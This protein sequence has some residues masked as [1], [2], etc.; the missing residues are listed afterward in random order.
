MSILLDTKTNRRFY[1]FD[2]SHDDRAVLY[3]QDPKRIYRCCCREHNQVELKLT[4]ALKFF[5]IDKTQIHEPDCER[6]SEFQESKLLNKAFLRQESSTF[7]TQLSDKYSDD[8]KHDNI[9]RKFPERS[10]VNKELSFVSF[11]KKVNMAAYERMMKTNKK[12][13]NGNHPTIDRKYIERYIWSVLKSVYVK[14]EDGEMSIYEMDNDNSFKFRHNYHLLDQTREFECKKSKIGMNY[15]VLP[16]VNLKGFGSSSIIMNEDD[17]QEAKKQFEKEY[18]IRFDHRNNKVM[19]FVK[20]EKKLD[21]IHDINPWKRG[22]VCFFIISNR[23]LYAK[24]ILESKIYNEIENCLMEEEAKG[25]HIQFFKPYEYT[26]GAYGG[27]FLEDGII[28]NSYKND[29]SIVIEIFEDNSKNIQAERIG[30]KKSFIKK[31]KY[32]PWFYDIQEQEK[33]KMTDDEYLAHKIQQLKS[34][35]E[36]I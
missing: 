29:K 19:A 31:S 33:L 25:K 26:P 24:S 6:S 36:K 10:K 17:F 15:Y 35:L 14:T 18:G 5:P 1:D 7:N 22:A 3:R 27:S 9:D 20:G 21:S 11:A 23:G 8:N 2:C 4:K 32:I 28:K 12:D 16:V 13:K 30:K 34:L